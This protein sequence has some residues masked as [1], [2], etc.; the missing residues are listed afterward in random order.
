MKQLFPFSFPIEIYTVFGTP[1]TPDPTKVR[2]QFSG[3]ST[4]YDPSLFQL[5]MV[6]STKANLPIPYG[7]FHL[8]LLKD[9][10]KI[11][12]SFQE[13]RTLS[14]IPPR[15][16]LFSVSAPGRQARE[17]FFWKLSQYKRVDSCGRVFRNIEPPLD[18][19]DTGHQMPEYFQFIRQY[20][21]M[22][23]FENTSQ[24]FYFTEKLINAYHAGTIPIYW[25]CPNVSDYVNMDALLYLK[26]DYTEQDVVD[27][28]QEIIR[29]DQ[30]DD[31]Y[32]AKFESIFMNPLS[33]L[34]DLKKIQS[35]IR[36]TLCK[37]F[38]S[39]Y[40]NIQQTHNNQPIQSPIEGVTCWSKVSLEDAVREPTFRE[41]IASHYD[42]PHF[43]FSPM[44][45]EGSPLVTD[46]SKV[47]PGISRNG[48]W[49]LS[50]E[51]IHRYPKSYYEPID[52]VVIHC[53]TNQ[54]RAKNIEIQEARLGHPIQR[55]EAIMGKDVSLDR[56]DQY[57]PRIRYTPFREQRG[58]NEIGCY[59]SH[60]TLLQSRKHLKTGYT[61]I[62]EDDFHI[63]QDLDVPQL[64]QD[65]GE[66]DILYLGHWT[67]PSR[68][69][70]V[71][72]EVYEYQQSGFLYFLHAYVVSNASIESMYE[73]MLDIREPIDW[74]FIRLLNHSYPN[75]SY[76]GKIVHP[77]KVIQNRDQMDSI[78]GPILPP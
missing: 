16:C 22:I 66:F 33:D 11:L 4:F 59:L 50:R 70:H 45:P 30:D 43:Y 27:L 61:V 20:K 40:D 38:P 8:Q 64:I 13:R 76:R 74:V 54:E 47:V 21:F 41:Y 72:G 46:F 49:T 36:D 35:N 28:I 26:P 6:P 78:I 25:G 71:K 24:P 58:M 37:V 10:D 23:C 68:Y 57:D 17:E 29:L 77:Q 34:F 52:Y 14:Q 5:N 55:F 9:A 67:D 19:S 3:E 53:G 65:A 7:F 51:E 15:F 60:L 75:R 73:T 12:A 63:V 62:F 69:K 44:D 32:R 42:L 2:V 18:R 48:V 56:L 1:P 39:T 31:A